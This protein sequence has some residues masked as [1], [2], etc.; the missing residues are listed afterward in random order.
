[1]RFL[2]VITFS[3]VSVSLLLSSCAKEVSEN[4]LEVSKTSWSKW[5]AHFIETHPDQD[6]K[7]LGEDGVYAEVLK[8][9]PVDAVSVEVGNW[10]R[11]N[12]TGRSMEGDVFVTRDS[13]TAA[14]QGT[15]TLFTHYVPQYVL[16]AGNSAYS[17]IPYGQYLAIKSM[18]QGEK[19]RVY[20]PSYLAYGSSGTSF[21]KG[22]QG[23]NPLLAGSNVTME[24]ELVEV[25]KDITEFENKNVEKRA[26]TDW[27]LTVKDTVKT[28]FYIQRF[29][30]TQGF[31]PVPDPAFDPMKALD[32]DFDPDFV[33]DSITVDSMAKIYYIGRFLD[34]FVFDTNIDSVAKRLWDDNTARKVLSFR[35][36]DGGYIEAFNLAIPTMV[37]NQCARFVFTSKY[38]YGVNGSS[39]G[40][41]VIQPYSP[42]IFEIYILPNA[43]KKEEDKE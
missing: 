33:R 16:I 7:P 18:K 6:I 1:M 38:G 29:D 41:T 23:Q 4:S 32:P 3:L 42:L 12:Y 17:G 39:E 25:I 5:I 13:M 22:Y 9:A 20:I 11:I 10:V 43:K 36:K 15:V 26:Q 37:Y 2:S 28:N 34:G 24:I 14:Q 31:N 21:S 27:G 35:P 30:P 19:L 8:T 40:K